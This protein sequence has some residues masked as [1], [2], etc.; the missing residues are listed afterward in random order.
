M[1]FENIYFGK[2]KFKLDI[3]LFLRNWPECFSFSLISAVYTSKAK[4]IV[5]CIHL[6]YIKLVRLYF[7]SY[8]KPDNPDQSS[9]SV[10]LHT[11]NVAQLK[12][13]IFLLQITE[14]R[15]TILHSLS[16]NSIVAVSNR[17][18]LLFIDISCSNRSNCN[19]VRTR[20]YIHSGSNTVCGCINY[21]NSVGVCV[22]HICFCSI[23]SDCYSCGF[24][25]F[26]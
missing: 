3:Y 12:D 25:L 19:S 15:R 16:F 13:P 23:W 26:S 7:G 2:I 11:E 20:A 18:V 4:R 22:R 8:T 14:G 24:L 9:P 6:L 10:L 21:R 5:R 1:C 17:S